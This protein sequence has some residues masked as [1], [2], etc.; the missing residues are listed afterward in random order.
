M[1]EDNHTQL[2]PS[3]VCN[4]RSAEALPTD[5]LIINPHKQE[6]ASAI[7]IPLL[8]QRLIK[9]YY[10]SLIHTILTYYIIEPE[11]KLHIPNIGYNNKKRIRHFLLHKYKSQKRI[12]KY[13]CLH[14]FRHD[15]HQGWAPTSFFILVFI[16]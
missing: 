14:I 12:W 9:Q 4:R 15:F 5:H 7:Y 3:I 13:F 11:M 6:S 16:Y 2:L 8:Y 10:Q 1:K